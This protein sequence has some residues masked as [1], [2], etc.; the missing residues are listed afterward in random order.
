M[1]RTFRAITLSAVVAALLAVSQAASAD[2][3]IWMN[4]NGA[5]VAGASSSGSFASTTVG[6]GGVY[7]QSFQGTKLDGTPDP[8]I[9]QLLNQAFVVINQNAAAVDIELW[10]SASGYT[11]PT[12]PALQFESSMSG[13]SVGGQA[14]LTGISFQAWAD[15]LDRLGDAGGVPGTFT[16]G[17]QLVSWSGTSFDTGSAFGQFTRV[18]NQ[19]YSVTSVLRFTLAPTTTANFNSQTNVRQA[20]EPASLALVG[21]A[22]AGLGFAS[23]R[24][25]R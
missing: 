21:L 1:T 5:N 14:L 12:G 22:F 24:R 16:N 10:A 6:G 4:V 3:K 8:N 15:E 7:F 13:T 9:S 23:W 19:P 20:P 17:N 11:L 2:V 25:R 18:A